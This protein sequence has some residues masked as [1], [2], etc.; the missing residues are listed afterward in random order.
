MSSYSN[1]HK[2]YYTEHKEEIAEKI[3]DKEYW[4]NYYLKNKDLVKQKAL[5]RY[6]AKKEANQPIP[7]PPNPDNNI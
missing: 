3:K 1:Y 5:A 7:H 6:Y 2:K 4:K